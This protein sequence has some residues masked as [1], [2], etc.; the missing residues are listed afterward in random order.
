MPRPEALYKNVSIRADDFVELDALATD[1]GL[2]K[3]SLLRKLVRLG[4]ANLR[5]LL[6]VD[7]PGAHQAPPKNGVRAAG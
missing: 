6:L 3:S 1:T 4:R 5:D 7:V 2:T